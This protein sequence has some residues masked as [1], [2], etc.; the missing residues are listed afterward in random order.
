M[1]TSDVHF[2]LAS[3]SPRRIELLR[4]RGYLFEVMPSP[5]VEP[6]P[7][8]DNCKPTHW[9][10][11][12]SYFKARSVAKQLA[13]GV[14]LA[15]DTIVAHEDHL[16]GKPRDA[17]DARRILLA[18]SGTTHQVITG[19]TLLDAAS[20]ERRIRHDVTEVT[21]REMRGSV[22][23]EYLAKGLWQGKAGAYG[24]QDRSDANVERISGSYSNVVGLPMELV[25][26]MLAEV[27]IYADAPT[28]QSR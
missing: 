21:M 14:V 23:E 13:D 16:F 18:L 11:A 15:A 19:V 7:R 6:E 2:V 28:P 24:I 10:E 1:S 26:A 8:S 12:L 9:A 20:G 17:D 4:E 22:L 27:G 5:V 3:N 25:E